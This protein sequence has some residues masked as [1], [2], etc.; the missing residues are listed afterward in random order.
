MWHWVVMPLFG[1]AA[2][3]LAV[4]LGAVTFQATEDS[5]ISTV[6]MKVFGLRIER[7]SRVATGTHSSRCAFEQ[8]RHCYFLAF[9]DSDLEDKNV[10]ECANRS[11]HSGC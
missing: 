5:G 4:E 8:I 9:G 1:L 10:E 7:Q 11:V 6:V 2:G 3:V